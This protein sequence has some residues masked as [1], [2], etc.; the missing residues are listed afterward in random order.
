MRINQGRSQA[1]TTTHL[2]HSSQATILCSL[3]K[4]FAA[5]PSLLAISMMTFS[6]D[7]AQIQLRP[8]AHLDAIE[9]A[10]LFLTLL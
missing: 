3:S 2:C 1:K 4:L 5:I 10:A 6:I 8:V 7:V 9:G